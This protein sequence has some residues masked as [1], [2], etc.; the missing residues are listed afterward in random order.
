MT[1]TLLLQARTNSSR[2]PGK[3]LLP[4]A[5]IPLVVLAARRAGNTGHRV[6]VVTSSE[7]SDNVLCSVLDDW[8]VSYFRGDL[9][10]TLKRFV[11]ALYGVPDDQIVVRLTGDNVFPDG[12][13]IDEMLEDFKARD[14]EYLCS[15]GHISGLPY[16]VSAEI[17]RAG[18]LREANR[19]AESSFEREHVTPCIID[20]YGCNFFKKY[21]SHG[22]F[23]YRCTVDTL[24]DYLLVAGLFAGSKKPESLSV[25]TLMGWLKDASPSIVTQIPATRFVL[26]TAQF[27]LNYGIANKTGRP[28]QI[29]VNNLVR[30]AITNGVQY[31]DTARA[32][33]DSE[34]ALGKALAGGWSS[35]ITVITKLSPLDDCPADASADV[36]RVFAER[37][38]YQSC[39]AM[40]VASL[41]VVMLHRAAHFNAWDGAIWDTLCQLRQ[42]GVIDQLGVSVQSPEEALGA[43]EFE[44]V[45][46]IQLPF[47]I[48]DYR[49]DSVIKKISLVREHRPI[50]VHAR[51]ALLQG[52]LTSNQ[53]ELWHR[54]NCSAPACV[55]DWL[56]SCARQHAHDDVVELCLR[57]VV[58]QPWID[59]VVIGVDTEE[60]LVDNLIQVGASH[61]SEDQLTSIVKKRPRVSE[62]TLN[63]ST[64]RIANA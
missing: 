26:G 1:A 9:K 4:I 44:N 32:Y 24:D 14:I 11:D 22:M 17:T 12:S 21:Q 19:K 62:E 64:W 49:W 13:F 25:T 40:N 63:P 29:L 30:T 33:G 36:A 10:N 48:L 42:Q 39:H 55:I 28:E 3:V 34:Q 61:W 23:Q 18:L 58:S 56:R 53:E 7:P 60:H 37:S 46:Y 16:G 52:L 6:V 43:L 45:S 35:R 50:V 27:G 47:N 5:G 38:I 57:F 20:K 2:L 15:T 31:I 41:D 59:G 51:S 54:A 8:G